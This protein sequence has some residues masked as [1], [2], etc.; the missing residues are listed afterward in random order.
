MAREI[1][2]GLISLGTVSVGVARALLERGDYIL[3]PFVAPRVPRN[4]AVRNEATQRTGEPS[5]VAA[6]D[7]MPR[8]EGGA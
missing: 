2:V 8:D 1:G 4:A 6:I 7:V 5:V 3:G